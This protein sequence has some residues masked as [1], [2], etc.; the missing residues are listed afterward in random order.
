MPE[1]LSL[2]Q[3]RRIALAAQ[4]FDTPRPGEDGTRVDLRHVRR[5]H[6]RVDV[7]QM[8]SVNVAVRAHQMPL[9]AR[10]GPHP[11][12]I[13]ER[14]TRS[15]DV[16]EAWCHEASLLP[17]DAWPL[18][19]WRR[20]PDADMW[21]ETRDIYERRPEYVEDIYEQVKDSGPLWAGD[22]ADPGTKERIMFDRSDG[23]N[24][25]EYLFQ[26]GRVAA[27]HDSTSFVRYYDL[28]ERMIPAEVRAR[29]VLAA[30]DAKRALLDR[31]GQALGIA[32]DRC[33]AD[34]HRL[35]LNRARPLI[36]DL[37][38]EGRLIPIRVRGWREMTFLHA[39]AR[40]PRWIRA[41]TLLTPVDSLVWE[42][43]RAKALFDFE[44]KIEIYVPAEERVH[45]YYVLPFLMGDRLV[46]RIDVKA[47][48]ARKTLRVKSAFA[49]PGV[50]LGE[51]AEAL[52]EELWFIAPW[53]ELRNVRVEQKGDLAPAL[54]AA[55]AKLRY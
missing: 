24:A 39:D 35:N 48:R 32:T 26:T 6:K 50:D 18:L 21:A 25:L 8:D 46:A 4:G 23:K 17:I 30:D 34:Y 37:V 16:F 3:A 2:A 52:A 7:V 38:E 53:L 42:R 29:P 15:G 45:G 47:D 43:T 54:T 44:Y 49:E 36:A 19:A 11:L 1:T 55:V 40:L 13:W 9:W 41:R 31:A 20:H 22:L 28:T 14:L 51:V 12:D 27:W 10:L 33:L 5:V